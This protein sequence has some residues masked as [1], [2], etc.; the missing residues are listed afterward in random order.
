MLAEPVV[1]AIQAGAIDKRRLI[2][3]DDELCILDIRYG[4]LEND[5][6]ARAMGFTNKERTYEFAGNKG[7]VTRQIG[8]AVACGV[9]KALLTAALSHEG[10][11]A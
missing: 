7:E 4:M 11:E 5:E 3:I 2:I 1:Q 9:A 10:E 6:L 8:N